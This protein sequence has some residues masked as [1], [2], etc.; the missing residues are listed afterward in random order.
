MTTTGTTPHE[1][2]KDQGVFLH[3]VSWEQYEAILAIRGESSVPRMTY[4]RGELEL[5]SPSM[6]H[7]GIKTMIGRLVEAYAETKRIDLNGFGSWTLKEKALELGAEA[8][9]CYIIGR[10]EGRERPDFAIEVHWTH[11]GLDK[12]EVYRGLEVPEVWMYEEDRIVIYQLLDNAYQ[13]VVRS[14]Y[15]P[16]LDLAELLEYLDIHNQSAA[17]R[18]YRVS[19][20]G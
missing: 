10:A 6:D 11:G 4:L 18:A 8:D 20:A 13:R 5:M 19:L 3:N 2:Q 1:C 12:L 7:E 16:N 15:L 14:D 9:E 17:V